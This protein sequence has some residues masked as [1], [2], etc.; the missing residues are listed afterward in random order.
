MAK[1]ITHAAVCGTKPSYI[2]NI[3]DAAKLAGYGPVHRLEFTN[4]RA[5]QDVANA[6][7]AGM[8]KKEAAQ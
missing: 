2:L 6:V 8:A 3:S 4:Y 1:K 5:A 7:K